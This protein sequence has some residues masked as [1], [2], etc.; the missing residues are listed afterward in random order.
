VNE[1]SAASATSISMIGISVAAM[2]T[3]LGVSRGAARRSDA[4]RAANPSSP[5]TM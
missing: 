4:I 1:N 2:T 5:L 3:A